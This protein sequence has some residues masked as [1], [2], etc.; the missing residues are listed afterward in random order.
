MGSYL[1]SFAE[2]P[3]L[4]VI[5]YSANVLGSILALAVILVVAHVLRPTHED[6]L[7]WATTI[8]TVGY[9]VIAV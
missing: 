6:R 4:A 9:S 8:G 2:N 7:C 1:L 3:T 5:E